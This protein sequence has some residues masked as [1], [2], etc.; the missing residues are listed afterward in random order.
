M[1]ALLQYITGGGVDVES[2]TWEGTS[3]E[4]SC[5][6]TCT[7]TCLSVQ[8]LHD[9]VSNRLKLLLLLV[10]L[11]HRSLLRSIQPGGRII[12]RTLQLRLVCGIEF[13][14][15]LFITQG[16]A[17]VVRIRLEAILRRNTSGRRLTLG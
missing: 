2:T 1:G 7:R 8:L 12:Y 14:G 15:K 5:T 3:G 4:S 17:E 9:R 13:V 11:L 6:C 16:V 10:V